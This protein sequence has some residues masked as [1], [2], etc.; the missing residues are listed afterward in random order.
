M[1]KLIDDWNKSGFIEVK[2]IPYIE[3]T[4]LNLKK[5]SIHA[6][7]D[8]KVE[9]SN[10]K[11]DQLGWFESLYTSQ[12][13]DYDKTAE[14][15]RAEFKNTII[16]QKRKY[17]DVYLRWR[18]AYKSYKKEEEGYKKNLVDYEKLEPKN[19]LVI[20]YRKTTEDLPYKVVDKAFDIAIKDQGRRP[21]CASFAAIY[22]IG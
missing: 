12:K 18:E 3:D 4:V 16:D 10:N 14:E 22:A 13:K 9:S 19:D 5:T 21:T 15:M 7:D 1:V 6:E 20:K 8:E 2:E 17:I 11:D